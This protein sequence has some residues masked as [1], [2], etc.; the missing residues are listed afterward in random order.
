MPVF[1]QTEPSAPATEKGA[2][3]SSEGEGGPSSEPAAGNVDLFWPQ[4]RQLEM[5]KEGKTTRKSK[6]ERKGEEA[7]LFPFEKL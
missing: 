2:G 3:F 5:K 6:R 7:H 1:F 4:N